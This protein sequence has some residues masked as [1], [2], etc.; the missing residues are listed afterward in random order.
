MGVSRTKAWE[1]AEGILDIPRR[2]V[3][4]TLRHGKSGL[5]LLH[6]GRVLTRCYNSQVGRV[7][8]LY[9]A[10]ALG[11][12]LPENGRVGGRIRE[13]GGI[14]P[15]YI[16]IV[17]GLE[18]ARDAS[19]SGSNAGGGGVPA[20]VTAL[21][22][23]WPWLMEEKGGAQTEKEGSGD[24]RPCLSLSI[25]NVLY[26]FPNIGNDGIRRLHYSVVETGPVE[27]RLSV[28]IILTDWIKGRIPSTKAL[29][30]P[31]SLT[32]G[33]WFLT[34]AS[35]NQTISGTLGGAPSLLCRIA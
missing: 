31:H 26:G 8:A 14:V 6:R 2:R 7:A 9:V 22:E 15:G 25:V 3:P 21:G 13:Y 23:V 32:G 24:L 18:E 17:V 12:E 34:R 16:D 28:A 5:V 33:S 1:Y 35:Q 29:E 4:V 27:E 20:G 11:V 10:Q 19:D 30:H